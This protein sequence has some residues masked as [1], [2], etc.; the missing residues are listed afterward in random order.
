MTDISLN[1]VYTWLRQLFRLQD[2]V[3]ET[4]ARERIVSNIAFKGHNLWALILA[5]IVASVGLNV[6]STAVIIG[7]MLI[8]PLMGPILGAG[9]ALGINDASLLRRSARYLAIA[10]VVSILTS[11]LYF[12]LS[13]LADA[14]SELLARTRP[15]IYDVLIA[16]AGGTAGIIA[17]CQKKEG[18]NV[19]P[20]VA[21]ATAL[22][23]PLCTAGFGL[24]TGEMS[25]FFGAMYLYV[26]NATFICLATLAFVR[27]LRFKP[28]AALNEAGTTRLRLIIGIVTTIIVLPSIYVAWTVV[29]ETRFDSAARRYIAENLEFTDRSVVTTRV[30]R[31]GDSAFIEATI[32]G[33]PLTEESKIQLQGRL[34]TYGLA[35]TRL[36]LRQPS[37][38]AMSAEEIGERVRSGILED[39]YQRNQSAIESRDA[40][41]A[42]LEGEVLRLRTSALPVQKAAVE[43]GTLYP[44]LASLLYGAAYAADTTQASDST[45]TIVAAWR[46]Q[47]T[48]AERG[49]IEAFLANRLGVDSVRVQ[50]IQVR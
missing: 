29:Q 43:L 8:S 7:A 19:I 9:L 6:N 48:A 31:Q 3:D 42:L 32:L 27:F 4:A 44:G 13:P 34:A 35:N 11:A 45:G 22:M 23:P 26:I 40:R 18:G 21:I 15:T 2:D 12:A 37:E 5:I 10:T 50:H 25:F 36:V 33:T 20:G 41:I 17:A 28:V 39:L 16:L 30:R 38:G 24:A 47:P 46:R 1:S 14:Q 49:R